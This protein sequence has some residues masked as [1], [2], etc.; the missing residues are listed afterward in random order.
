MRKT[1]SHSFAIFLPFGKIRAEVQLAKARF[2]DFPPHEMF[3]K[4]ECRLARDICAVA[5]PV[6]VGTR[7]IER[8]T[9]GGLASCFLPTWR[10]VERIIDGTQVP[11]PAAAG[12]WSGDKKFIK[13][14]ELHPIAER[15]RKWLVKDFRATYEK[16]NAGKDSENMLEVMSYLDPRH[17]SLSFLASKEE[18]AAVRNRANILAISKAEKDPAYIEMAQR[19]AVAFA[20]RQHRSDAERMDPENAALATLA[21]VSNATVKAWKVPQLRIECRQRRIEDWGVRSVLVERLL[22]WKPP[23][24]LGLSQAPA[25]AANASADAL[26]QSLQEE[27]PFGEADLWGKGDEDGRPSFGEMQPLRLAAQ[28]RKELDGYDTEAQL[29]AQVSPLAWWR[30]HETRYPYLAALA[31]DL[32]AAPGSAAALEHMFSRA[33]KVASPKRPRLKPHMASDVLLPREHSAQSVLIGTWAR[34][35]DLSPLHGSLLG[36]VRPATQGE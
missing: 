14:E 31:R 35:R 15:L 36:I 25:A 23:T 26:E 8:D 33:A 5:E 32:L 18:R 29:C 13:T 20:A 10:G 30:S 27:R 19:E 2:K 16:F 1:F 17:K 6:Q 3:E 34:A 24:P 12:K 9:D 11:A 7:V 4:G 22:A 28:L 21:P